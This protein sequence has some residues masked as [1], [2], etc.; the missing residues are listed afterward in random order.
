MHSSVP[1]HRAPPDH[2][3]PTPAPDPIPR[4]D[5]LLA[6]CQGGAED[7]IA[8]RLA[9]A[10]PGC[11]RG[12]WRRGAVSFKLPA[13]SDPSPAAL[14]RVRDALAFARALFRC[15]GQ[16]HWTDDASRI[17]T[18]RARLPAAR[19]DAVHLYPRDVRTMTTS[20]LVAGVPLAAKRAGLVDLFPGATF[21]A[22]R[23][24]DLVLDCLA[25]ADDRWWVG[26]HRATTPSTCWPGGLYPG[27]IPGDKV[28]RAW[29]KLDEAIH[30]FAIEFQPGS[31]AV[32]L[33]ASPG[34]AC[35][36]LLEAGLEVVGIDPAL[37]DPVVAA[38]PGFTQWRKRARDVQLRELRGFDWVVSDM[39]IDPVSSMESIGRV[40]TAPGS[41]VEGIIATLKLPDWSRAE[42]LDGWL[43]AFRAWGFAPQA[44]QLSTGG[45]EVCV[46]ARRAAPRRGA[47]K[48]PGVRRRSPRTGRPATPR[49]DR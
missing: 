13:G 8:A 10:L 19:Y 17:E 22:A 12:A 43:G 30:S 44:R 23:P 3:P 16:V 5:F 34:G 35:Q 4:G 6:T 49:A 38:L 32:E 18:L 45:R 46:C 26:W 36:R 31:R 29:L 39:N 7:V 33:G 9:S 11:T 48:A 25:D 42:S 24:G 41:R 21:A 28:S 47:A 15:H 1:P 20:E 27:A 2:A 14:D 40:V 37:V